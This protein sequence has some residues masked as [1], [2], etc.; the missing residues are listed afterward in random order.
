MFCLFSKW[1]LTNYCYFR[2]AYFVFWPSREEIFNSAP[3]CFKEN[4]PNCVCIIDCSEVRTEKPG[5]LRKQNAL[6]SFYKSSHTFKF[7]VGKLF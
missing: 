6:Y 2:A 3:E 5:G 1:Q 7:L 4:Y